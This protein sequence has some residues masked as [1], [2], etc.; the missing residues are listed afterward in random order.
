MVP[1]VLA[2]L[3]GQHVY[4][5]I[6]VLAKFQ[7]LTIIRLALA[8]HASPPTLMPRLTLIKSLPA[9]MEVSSDS[10]S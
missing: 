6:H 8:L 9:L 7:I 5:L 4:K 10:L 2:L 3:L 1:V